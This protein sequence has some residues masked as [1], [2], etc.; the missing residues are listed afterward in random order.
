MNGPNA[1]AAFWGNRG[2]AMRYHLGTVVNARLQGSGPPPPEWRRKTNIQAKFGDFGQILKLEVPE[3]NVASIEYEDKR[4]AEDAVRTLDGTQMF[5]RTL[6]VKISDG[7]DG[8]GG[9][10]GGA[11]MRVDVEAKVAELAGRF[12]LDEAAVVGLMSVF[13]ERS[14]LGCNLQKDFTEMGQHLA[15]SNKP[16][17]FICTKL[18]EL[19]AG[20][21]LGPCRYS[22][23]QAA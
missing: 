16:S 6:T 15:A 20:R 22:R 8:G 5:G 3:G 11:G 18:A 10:G 1:D 21:D 4:D 13:R 14:R 19:R 7:R 23:D 2:A 12:S 17:A 9:G